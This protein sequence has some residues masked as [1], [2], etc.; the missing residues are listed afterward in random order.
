MTM[1]AGYNRRGKFNWD[2]PY[3]HPDRI[4]WTPITT[5]GLYR[6]YHAEHMAAVAEGRPWHRRYTKE[7]GDD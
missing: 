1:R 7:D 5:V 4:T 2:V 3:G 6:E